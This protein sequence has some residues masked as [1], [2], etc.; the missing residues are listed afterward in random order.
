MFGTDAPL[1]RFGFEG[2]HNIQPI[3]AYTENIN[4]IKAMIK[5]ELGKEADS[6][7]EK[8]FYTNSKNLYINKTWLP[9]AEKISQSVSKTKLAIIF[10]GIV[11]IIAGISLLISKTCCQQVVNSSQKNRE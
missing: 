7:I 1:S 2:E 5:Q 10:G 11:S 6:I 4:N 3:S 8:L 9:K